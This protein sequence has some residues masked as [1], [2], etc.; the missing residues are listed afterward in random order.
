MWLSLVLTRHFTNYNLIGALYLLRGT[1][2]ISQ[3]H[4][5][6]P[7]SVSLSMR[8]L[9]LGSK[10]NTDTLTGNYIAISGHAKFK[11]FSQD[12]SFTVIHS[13]CTGKRHSQT[14]K[15]CTLPEYFD[16]FKYEEWWYFPMG[17]VSLLLD[18]N[19]CTNFISL[20]VTQVRLHSWKKEGKKYQ[21]I[22]SF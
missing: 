22:T 16:E 7:P 17:K 18:E 6:L 5:N 20:T 13:P 10:T 15:Y 11:T 9:G 4:Q 2:D 14:R 3:L 1:I 21:N 12:D 19:G 8:G